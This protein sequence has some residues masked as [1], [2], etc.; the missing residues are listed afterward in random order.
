MLMDVACWRLAEM[1]VTT[2]SATPAALCSLQCCCC[3]APRRRLVLPDS[4]TTVSRGIAF[5]TLDASGR[6]SSILDSP[7][8]PVKLSARGLTVFGPLVQGLAGSM[9]PAVQELGR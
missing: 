1:P 7:E 2:T 6:I 3:G 5:C 4:N 8:H 9:L